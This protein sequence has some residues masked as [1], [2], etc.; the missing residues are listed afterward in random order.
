MIS[1]HPFLHNKLKNYNQSCKHSNATYNFPK[2]SQ[3]S[4]NLLSEKFNDTPVQTENF[5]YYN[6]QVTH[7]IGSMHN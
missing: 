2:E 6:M 4:M 3:L 1:D 7:K 5:L